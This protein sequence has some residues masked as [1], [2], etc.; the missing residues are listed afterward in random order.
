MIKFII[1]SKAKINILGFDNEKNSFRGINRNSMGYRSLS[2]NHY[3]ILRKDICAKTFPLSD[4]ATWYK[5]KK[6]KKFI[7]Q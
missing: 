6:E 7:R 2:K 3:L 4:R 1:D 5:S